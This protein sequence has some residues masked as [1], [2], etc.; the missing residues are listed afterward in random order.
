MLTPQEMKVEFGTLVI[1]QD[2]KIRRRWWTLLHRRWGPTEGGWVGEW[3]GLSPAPE[4]PSPRPVEDRTGAG[5]GSR[6][7]VWTL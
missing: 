4:D 6:E 5:V 2:L 3:R 7:I 1:F